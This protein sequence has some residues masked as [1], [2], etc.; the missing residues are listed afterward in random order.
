ML[1]FLLRVRNGL[2]GSSTVLAALFCS[3]RIGVEEVLL[4]R[5]IFP[6]F[7]PAACAF[8]LV[9]AGFSARP[10]FPRAFGYQEK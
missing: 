10:D 2:P 5:H 7:S 9:S 4:S 1:D 6:S 3:H 8:K